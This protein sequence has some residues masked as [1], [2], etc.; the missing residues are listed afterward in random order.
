MTTILV[1]LK[2]CEFDIIKI[3]IRK[4]QRNQ[5]YIYEIRELNEN[6][7]IFDYI[8]PTI[9]FHSRVCK[10]VIVHTIGDTVY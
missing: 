7:N 4:I 6:V 8:L 5:I 9:I 10:Y 1:K 3:F 2:L